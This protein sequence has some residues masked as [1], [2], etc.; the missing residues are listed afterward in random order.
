MIWY[1][2]KHFADRL[3]KLGKKN[4]PKSE[5]FGTSYFISLVV[6]SILFIDI[7]IVCAQSK[8]KT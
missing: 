5:L 2:V 8:K 6:E 7:R 1:R 4:G 3:C